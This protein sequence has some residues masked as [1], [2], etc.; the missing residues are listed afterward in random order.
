MQYAVDMDY[1][2]A[3]KHVILEAS[4]LQDL[5]EEAEQY[6]LYETCG[7]AEDVKITKVQ[8]LTEVRL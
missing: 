4:D 1:K 8:L 5:E 7:E 3:L 6:A 2:V